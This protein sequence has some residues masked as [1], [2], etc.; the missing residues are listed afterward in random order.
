MVSSSPRQDANL[1]TEEERAS[2]AADHPEP[3]ARA[4]HKTLGQASVEGGQSTSVPACIFSRLYGVPSEAGAAMLAK[5]RSPY[6]SGLEGWM[7]TRRKSLRRQEYLN[8]ILTH[9]GY[10][11][12]V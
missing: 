6:C 5:G 3:P 10:A 1:Y 2:D 7:V 4:T 8:K 11:Q 12:C 9:Y